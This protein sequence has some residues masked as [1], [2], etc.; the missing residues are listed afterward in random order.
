VISGVSPAA[1]QKNGL[2]NRKRNSSMTNTECRLTNVELS[3]SF[4]FIFYKEQSEA[5]PPFIFCGSLF[6]PVASGQSGQF[7]RIKNLTAYTVH[8]LTGS[9]GWT[10][11]RNTSP[12]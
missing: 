10:G 7:N 6:S 2:S 11:Y 12:K 4:Y 9:T 5:I 1:G 3:N 8:F